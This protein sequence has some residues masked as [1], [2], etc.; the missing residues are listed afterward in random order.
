MKGIIL[1]GG[2]G[3]RL[4]PATLAISKQMLPV[5]DKPMIYY[6]LSVL[7][8]TDIRDILVISTPRDVGSF[9][10]LLGDGSKWGLSLSYAVQTDPR[11]VADAF[12]IGEKFLD[13]SAVALVLGDNIFYGE[14]LGA[15][16]VTSRTGSGATIFAYRV[17][18]PERYGVVVFD[19][20]DNPI[21]IEEK[22]SSPISDWAI[23]GLYFYDHTVVDIAKSLQ[24]SGRNELEIADVNRTYPRR[25]MLKIE[26][27][28]R[29]IAWLDTGTHDSLLEASEF[30][31]AIE[32]RQGL[33]IA[34]IEEIAFRK[35]WIDANQVAAVGTSMKSTAYGQYLLQI[36]ASSSGRV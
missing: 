25:G 12:L 16:L 21:S 28:G 2:A 30:V 24:P 7:M 11:G 32:H 35:G 3:T 13:G 14:A 18:D 23:T 27:I 33:K 36:A 15:L 1:A 17:S 34:C 31:R 5:Y 20:S 22:P 4:Q 10:R 29:G 19:S 6:P 26:K 8:L 9:S